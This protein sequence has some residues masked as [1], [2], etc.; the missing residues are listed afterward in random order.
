MREI[1]SPDLPQVKHLN[2][3]WLTLADGVLSGP[4][5]GQRIFA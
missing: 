3:Y 4:W 5:N 2:P 1:A